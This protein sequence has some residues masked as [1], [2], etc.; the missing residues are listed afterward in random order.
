MRL[1]DVDAVGFDLDGTLVENVDGTWRAYAEA[2][3][4]LAKLR[5]S[6][7]RIGVL[8]DVTSDLA[9][10]RLM[11]AGLADA[12]DVVVGIDVGFAKPTHSAFRALETA[13]DV[14]RERLVFIGDNMRVDIAGARD[15][16]IR[17][18]LIRSS[19]R[20]IAEL[21]SALRRAA[22]SDLPTPVG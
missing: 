4:T 8:A 10:E 18:A 12:V 7:R 2:A 16:G 14:D 17:A 6:G 11:R 1:P 15:A 9:Y 5:A 20:A 13:L 21:P 22:A 3:E 19:G